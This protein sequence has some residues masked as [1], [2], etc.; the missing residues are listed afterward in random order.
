MAVTEG[1]RP[2]S[3]TQLGPGH[4]FIDLGREIQGGLRVE[5]PATSVAGTQASRGGRGGASMI[6]MS[7]PWSAG[8]GAPR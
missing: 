6:F 1:L 7:R 3:V 2:A 8:H 5:F 4:L